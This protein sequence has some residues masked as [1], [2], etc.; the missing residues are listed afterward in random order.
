MQPDPHMTPFSN[1]VR[2]FH[3]Q[4]RHNPGLRPLAPAS[5]ARLWRRRSGM[6][7]MAHSPMKINA[8][9]EIGF[10]RQKNSKPIAQPASDQTCKNST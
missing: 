9:S 7:E 6:Q 2:R 10:D 1:A 8:L 5:E 3:R 4:R